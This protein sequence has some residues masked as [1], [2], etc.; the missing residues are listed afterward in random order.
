MF[1]TFRLAF[2]KSASC[3]S[4]RFA[5]RV[6]SMSRVLKSRA[7]LST[8]ALS[9]KPGVAEL[10]P[11]PWDRIGPEP[12][13]TTVHGAAEIDARNADVLYFVSRGPDGTRVGEDGTV[14]IWKSEDGGE[15]WT[16]IDAPVGSSVNIG[17]GVRIDPP[18]PRRHRR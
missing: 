17:Q 13:A 15:A 6:A 10:S 3:S 8:L 4:G 14:N 7:V 1:S 18:C 9:G 16:R 11:S 12:T 5:L 2:F